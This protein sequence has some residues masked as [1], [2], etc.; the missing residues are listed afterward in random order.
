MANATATI[1]MMMRA[2]EGAGGMSRPAHTIPSWAVDQALGIVRRHGFVLVN[3]TTE[4]GRT[5]AAAG[6]VLAIAKALS[7]FASPADSH[8]DGE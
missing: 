6:L 2:N 8:V 5:E 3:A 4:E 1:L 7:K